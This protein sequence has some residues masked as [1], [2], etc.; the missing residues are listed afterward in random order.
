MKMLIVG[1]SGMIG[2]KIY[3]HFC[4]KNDVEM[5]YLTHKISFGKSHQLDILQKEDAINLIQKINPDVL[6]HNTALVSVDLCETDKKLANSINVEGTK[7]I[8]KAALETGVKKVIYTSSSA[9]F[10]IPD[11]NPV[12]TNTLPNPLE[13]YGK[14]KYEA[15]L[16]CKE[17]V[18]K[19]LDITIIRPRTIL[20]QGRLGIFYRYQIKSF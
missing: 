4:K 19:G 3:D 20:G 11:N 12:T 10:G 9:V 17:Y 13:A 7:N 16:I 14:A 2:T 8:L 1:G 18:E 15:E 5:T 6:V